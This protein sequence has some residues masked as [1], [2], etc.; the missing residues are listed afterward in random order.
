MSF[1]LEDF[2]EKVCT[3][4]SSQPLQYKPQPAHPFKPMYAVR[5]PEFVSHNRCECA[6]LVTDRA[7][8]WGKGWHKWFLPGVGTMVPVW[9]PGS[10]VVAFLAPWRTSLTE[11]ENSLSRMAG[12][13]FGPVFARNTQ[14]LHLPGRVGAIS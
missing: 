1:P 10:V 13:A 2:V 14:L 3:C 12:I 7:I 4:N 5:L 6:K 9:H 8:L 11:P